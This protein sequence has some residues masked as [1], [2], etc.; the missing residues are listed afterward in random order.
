MLFRALGPKKSLG[1]MELLGPQADGPK[2]PMPWARAYAPDR[3]MCPAHRA[4]LGLRPLSV[5][6]RPQQKYV[7]IKSKK[8]VFKIGVSLFSPEVKHNGENQ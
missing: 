2:G 4:M 7:L 3:L 6:R 1:P 8:I 5:G